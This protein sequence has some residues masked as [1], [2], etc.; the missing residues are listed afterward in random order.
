[1]Q[2]GLISIKASAQTGLSRLNWPHED[3][4]GPKL[5]FVRSA[6]TLIRLGDSTGRSETMLGA[7]VVSLVF[8]RRVLLI[9]YNIWRFGK[10]HFNIPPMQYTAIFNS[11]CNDGD[12]QLKNCDFFRVFAQNID[13]GYT[14]FLFYFTYILF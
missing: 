4:L 10:L 13:H 2:R 7:L 5:L 11:R 1:M 3:S 14:L 6:K 12:F 8:S 9:S